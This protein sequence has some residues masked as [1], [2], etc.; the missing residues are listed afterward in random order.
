MKEKYGV[1]EEE[2]KSLKDELD[3]KDRI[4]INENK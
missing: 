3:K 4:I 2:I 1:S